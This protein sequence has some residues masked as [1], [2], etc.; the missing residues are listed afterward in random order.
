M[1]DSAKRPAPLAR[2][3]WLKHRFF[4]LYMLREAT[5]LPLVFFL[6][7]LLA[8]MVAL[9]KGPASWQGWVAFMGSPVVL[10]LNLL[11]L[12]AS[13]YHA[14]TFF[15]LFPRVMPL[16]I[17]G[18]RLPDTAIVVGQWVGVV[19]VALLLFWLLGRA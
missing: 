17:A 18:H 16:R 15:V 11:A 4:K 19:V 5:V 2:T 9:F 13:L 8:G 1:A 10:A 7:C 6:L 14:A 12:A 3:W